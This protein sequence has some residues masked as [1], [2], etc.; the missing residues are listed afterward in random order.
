M[1]SS[2]RPRELVFYTSQGHPRVRTVIKTKSNGDR[3]YSPWL[4]C[5]AQCQTRRNR[6]AFFS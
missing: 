1:R 3:E 6:F 2:K 5:S 4:E